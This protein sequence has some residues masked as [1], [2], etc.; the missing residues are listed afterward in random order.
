[1][2]VEGINKV[3][4]IGSG[5]I[6]ACMAVL[7]TGNGYPTTM[8]AIDDTQAASGLSRYDECYKDLIKQGLVTEKQAMACKKLLKVTLTYE[9]IADVDFIFECV[10]EKIDVKYGVYE[11][12]EKNCKKFKAIASSTSAISAKDLAD[13]LKTQKDKLVVAH[14][15]N[16]PH[17]VPLVEVVKSDYTSEDTVKIV[18]SILESMGRKVAL[19]N[20]DAPGFIA[21][22]LQHALI[23][24]SV[25]IIEQGICGPKDIDAA[26]MYSFMPRYTSIGLFEHQDN[27]GLDL[28]DNIEKYLF[29]DLCTAQTTQDFIKDKVKTG[30]L[31]VKTGKG[32]YDWNKESIEDL[33]YRAAK[34]YFQFFNWDLPKE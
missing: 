11:L 33:K 30:D 18:R 7:S 10:F 12:I 23:R 20:K 32:I 26:L 22:R 1:L 28:V 17:L 31:G 9:D 13:G 4:V 19:M 29:P 16:P 2:R 5:M 3:A 24:E 14:P 6:G 8:L 25:Y 27:A 21:N 34:P 15:L